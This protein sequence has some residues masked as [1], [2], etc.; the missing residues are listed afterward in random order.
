MRGFRKGW[1]CTVKSQYVALMKSGEKTFEVRTRIPRDMRKGDAL[2]IM[3]KGTRTLALVAR[4]GGITTYDR[5]ELYTK[6][7]RYQLRRACLELSDIMDYIKERP[8]VNFI[9]LTS[10]WIP[11]E[12]GRKYLTPEFYGYKCMPQG[13]FPMPRERKP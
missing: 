12:K 3:E 1:L 4:I 5:S 7:P 10:C 6:V 8:Q 13:F 11:S 9:E 2:F